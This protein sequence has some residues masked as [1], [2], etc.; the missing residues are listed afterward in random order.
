MTVTDAWG[1]AVNTATPWRGR[2]LAG[3]MGFVASVNGD[4]ERYEI[5]IR[6]RRGRIV[7]HYLPLRILVSPRVKWIPPRYRERPGAGHSWGALAFDTRD[8]AE[9]FMARWFVVSMEG[10]ADD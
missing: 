4:C 9:R 1:I 5:A 7:R 2:I 6:T 10:K 8:D 3:A